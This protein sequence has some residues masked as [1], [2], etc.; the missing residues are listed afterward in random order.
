MKKR[1][2]VGDLSFTEEE[3]RE[4]RKQEEEERNAQEAQPKPSPPKPEERISSLLSWLP[5]IS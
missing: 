5:F 1:C 4:L 3:L 2:E